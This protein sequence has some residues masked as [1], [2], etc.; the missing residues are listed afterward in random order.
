MDASGSTGLARTAV[1]QLTLL[2]GTRRIYGAGAWICFNARR[3]CFRRS[4]R[5]ATP[6]SLH[7][8]GGGTCRSRSGFSRRAASCESL[9][10]FGVLVCDWLLYVAGESVVPGADLRP[11]GSRGFSKRD[12]AELNAV[13]I[14][15]CGWSSAGGRRVSRFWPRGLL[16][17]QRTFGHRRCSS[18]GDA[19]NGTAINLRRTIGK[20]KTVDLAGRSRGLPI[21]A[22]SPESVGVVAAFCDQ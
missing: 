17:C 1:D 10:G 14:I 7:A 21:R 4:N 6:A 3:W 15:A 13:S 20:G 11:R 8:G 18:A 5:P 16:L 22:E 9:D 19:A 12:R 2:A